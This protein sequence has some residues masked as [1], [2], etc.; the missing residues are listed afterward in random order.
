[1]GIGARA[2]ILSRSKDI[3]AMER[4]K[5]EYERLVSPEHMGETYKVLYV[6]NTSCG[7]V[8]PFL[9]DMQFTKE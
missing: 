1:M 8:Y 6:G 3:K 2:D 7:E 5:G 4:I 9:R